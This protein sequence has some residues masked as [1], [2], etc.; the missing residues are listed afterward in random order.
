MTGFKWTYTDEDNVTHIV[1]LPKSTYPFTACAKHPQLTENDVQPMA[2]V[3]CIKC[4]WREFL[5]WDRVLDETN[6]RLVAAAG[7]PK[8]Y[9]FGEA[10]RQRKNR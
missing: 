8:E 7:I 1:A 6:K 10:R 4:W 5:E 9:V 3:N 2:P